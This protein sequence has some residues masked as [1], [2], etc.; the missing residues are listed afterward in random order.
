METWVKCVLCVYVLAFIGIGITAYLSGGIPSKP[1]PV[2]EWREEAMNYR[3]NYLGQKSGF[4]I[5]KKTGMPPAYFAKAYAIIVCAAEKIANKT[6]YVVDII[7]VR[8]ALVFYCVYKG[9]IA[10]NYTDACNNLVNWE[11][12]CNVPY[13]IDCL[14]ITSFIE[15]NEEQLRTCIN[16]CSF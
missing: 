12:A 11:S 7:D 16:E 4:C 2:V 1:L 14:E 6:D 5:F 9:F 10:G 3:D 8:A 15:T 13:S